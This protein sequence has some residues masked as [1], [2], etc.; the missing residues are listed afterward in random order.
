MCNVGL[1]PL[2][3][4]GVL[5]FSLHVVHIFHIFYEVVCF[6][7][8]IFYLNLPVFSIRIFLLCSPTYHFGLQEPKI[9]WLA[10]KIMSEQVPQFLG[11][12]PSGQVYLI[13]ILHQV[14]LP[15]CGL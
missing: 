1:L 5:I 8:S 9:S 3:A 12:S 7:H 13:S 14:L 11:K 6:L 15:Y 4:Q 2:D 10:G